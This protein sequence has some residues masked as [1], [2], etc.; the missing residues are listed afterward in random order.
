VEVSAVS[1]RSAIP[2]RIGMGR[3]EG[4]EFVVG[5]LFDVCGQPART[6]TTEAIQGAPA[7]ARKP[8]HKRPG[9]P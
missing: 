2:R 6:L 7:V 8:E 1:L 4:S 3:D 5:E 9:I